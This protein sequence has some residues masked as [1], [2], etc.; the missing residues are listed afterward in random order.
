[1]IRKELFRSEDAKASVNLATASQLSYI[2][3]DFRNK[4][5]TTN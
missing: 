1:M 4:P 3:D 5:T 2:E